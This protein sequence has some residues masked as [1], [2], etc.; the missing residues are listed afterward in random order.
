VRLL[1]LHP[2]TGEDTIRASLITTD[3]H[4]LGN[5]K[6]QY[7]ALSY[8]WGNGDETY[9]IELEKDVSTEPIK[10]FQDVVL[11]T[12]RAERFRAK[13]FYIK[14]NLYTALK[15]L[16]TSV[17]YVSLWIDAVCINQADAEEKSAQVMKMHSIYRKAYNVII[18]LGHDIVDDP[19]SEL[20][21]AFIPKV[22]NQDIHDKLLED[23]MFVKNWASLFELSKRDW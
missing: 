10:T 9:M 14:H 3:D 15:H 17:R 21:M 1:V 23:D 20:A 5:D 22:M 8:V 12:M 19:V 2:G 13:H 18:W 7:E 4:E 16:R 6:F 11:A